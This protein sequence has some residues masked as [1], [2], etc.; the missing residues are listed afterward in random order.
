MMQFGWILKILYKVKGASHKSLHITISVI[1]KSRKGSSIDTESR[2]VVAEGE[3]RTEGQAVIAQ[4]RGPPSGAHI[5]IFLN[6]LETKKLT[7]LNG[8][9]L[10]RY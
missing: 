5:H 4:K 6:V 7:T 8:W 3:E 1:R 9:M 10:L 2:S